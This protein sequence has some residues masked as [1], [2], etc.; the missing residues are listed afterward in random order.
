MFVSFEGI[1]G[2]G[3]STQARMLAE[4]LRA[5]GREVVTSREPG[6]T[7]LGE[8]VRALLLGDGSITPW[9]E[10]ALFAAARSQLVAEVI[11]PAL[12]RGADVVCD[13]FLD[14]SLAYQGVA[15]G[16][17]VEAVFA[18]NRVVLGDLLPDRTVLLLVPPEEAAGRVSNRPDRI[19]GEG[20]AFQ[21][22]VDRA[23]RE[24]AERFPARIVVLDGTGDP[25]EVARRVRATLGVHV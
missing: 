23:Y 16:L 9:A 14:S 22:Q 13:R 10:A 19:E 21:E 24:L 12:A 8:Q 20:R 7:A 11:G 15:R 6:G 2:S 3:K 5:E 17:G 18:L 25:E 4:A 1:D